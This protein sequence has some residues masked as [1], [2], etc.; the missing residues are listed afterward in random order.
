VQISDHK[1]TTIFSVSNVTTA[2]PNRTQHGQLLSRYINSI[3]RSI[4]MYFNKKRKEKKKMKHPRDCSI[5]SNETNELEK[6]GTVAHRAIGRHCIIF[7]FTRTLTYTWAGDKTALYHSLL[8]I[9]YNN[10]R[11]TIMCMYRV[12]QKR[13]KKPIAG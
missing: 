12:G 7:L 5:Y 1:S 2:N 13:E 6:H 11:M 10:D 3:C 4:Y 8:F 9:S